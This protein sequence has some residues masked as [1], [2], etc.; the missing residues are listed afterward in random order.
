MSADQCRLGTHSRRGCVRC[1]GCRQRALSRSVQGGALGPP[2]SKQE[3]RGANVGG[4]RGA[5]LRY[6]TIGH[7]R[8]EGASA[9]AVAAGDAR[10]PTFS[11]DI[12]D[13]EKVRA[14]VDAA[15]AAL[16]GLSVLVCN[17]A[18]LQPVSVLD[19]D[20]AM[21]EEELD[22]NVKG[23]MASTRFA[24]PHILASACETKGV[25]LV[26][27]ILSQYME[28]GAA[29]YVSS[30]HALKGF[31]GCLFGEVREKGV[32][33]C[34]IMPGFVA[35][36]MVQV[37]EGLIFEN[38]LKPD[39]VAHAVECVLSFSASACPIE[40]LLRPQYSA[41]GGTKHLSWA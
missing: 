3:A 24:L 15:A 1:S 35:T 12:K 13:T 40:I 30:K 17:A 10:F 29:G 11:V 39:D 33:V 20:P 9:A 16:G 14:A 32:K 36:E 22:V 31:A 7:P 5:P 6:P 38:M 37:F 23:T 8:G 19:G 21:W 41:E 25:I 28:P 18:I 4:H 34:L 2:K 27:S 26:G